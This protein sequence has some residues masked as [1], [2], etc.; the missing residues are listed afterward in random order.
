MAEPCPTV[1]T[2]RGRHLWFRH[3]GGHIG[4]RKLADHIDVRADAGYVL[5]PPS[6]HP[7]GRTYA[8][9]PGF[10]FD[11]PAPGLPPQV[12]AMLLRAPTE[13]TPS[14]VSNGNGADIIPEGRRNAALASIAGSMR[15]CGLNANEIV[16]S[17]AVVNSA[18]CDPPLSDRE[19]RQ[20]ADSI[21]RYAPA[22]DTGGDPSAERLDDIG[23]AARFAT[24]HC[25]SARYAPGFGWL[26]WDGRRWRRDDGADRVMELAKATARK[27]YS[28]AAE[29]DAAESAKRI[30]GWARS[31]ASAQR[32]RAMVDLARSDPSLLVSADS[33]DAD[34]FLLNVANGTVDLRTGTLRPHSPADLITKIAMVHFDP[35]ATATRWRQFIRE[36][37][38]ADDDLIAFLQRAIGSALTGDTRD[39]VLFVL[40]GLGANG[41]S[42]LLRVLLAILGEYGGPMA[43]E[44]L[45][46]AR[47]QNGPSED[48]ARLLGLRFVTA[49]ESG[50]GRAFNEVVLKQLTG[51]DPVNARFLHQNSFTFVPTFKLFVAAN[52]LPK[53][54]GTEHAIWRRLRL[55]PFAATFDNDS[56]ARARGALPCDEQLLDKLMGELPGVLAWM[57]QGCLMWQRDGLGMPPAVREATNHYRSS[58]DV[59]A[60]F[61]A[62][63]CIEASNASV[64]ATDLYAAYRAWA[65]ANGER[66]L[67]QREFGDRLTERHIPVTVRGRRRTKYR[68]GIALKPADAAIE[69]TLPDEPDF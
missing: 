21:G 56:D 13:L 19:V 6:V 12:A 36:I 33:L 18:H 7:S 15:R 26:L 5:L 32:L 52:H 67:S 46:S 35:A 24:Q 17:L 14:P 69:A 45:T 50:D 23:N 31:S 27:L 66:Q 44:T 61:I 30:A 53:V 49:S 28:E 40:H 64:G 54:R 63:R 8:W 38:Q 65:S 55:I 60:D 10:D 39:Q 9:L 43:F 51:G 62:D 68:L 34:P 4:N 37:M 47:R 25:E 20:I 58:Q 16:P 11:M 22:A 3:P 59:V 41:K 48:L 57:V 1:Q 29:S 42:V 2:V